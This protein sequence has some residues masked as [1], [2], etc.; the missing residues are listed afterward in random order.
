MKKENMTPQE[1]IR[2]FC[3]QCIQTDS[4]KD[5]RTCGGDEMYGQGDKNNVCW[6][7]PYR[8]G[9]GRP[10]VKVIRK[11]CLECLGNSSRLVEHCVTASCPIYD[12]RLGKNPN[13][14]YKKPPLRKSKF[15]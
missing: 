6:F 9:K 5:V 11:N 15:I 3:I 4:I 14:K 1:A 13:M 2:K 10:S 12:Y 7:Y 8:M